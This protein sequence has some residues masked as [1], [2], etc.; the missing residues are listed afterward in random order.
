MPTISDAVRVPTI[1]SKTVQSWI[2]KE[3]ENIVAE[4]HRA[5]EK[6][7]RE[8]I[9]HDRRPSHDEIEAADRGGP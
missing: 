1:A 3:N 9:R 4:L 8:R 5:G 7:E 6:L 2:E